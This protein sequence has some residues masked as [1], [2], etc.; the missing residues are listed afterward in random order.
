MIK[1]NIKN[2]EMYLKKFSI[3]QKLETM[4]YF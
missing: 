2:N 1:K 4:L 3:L